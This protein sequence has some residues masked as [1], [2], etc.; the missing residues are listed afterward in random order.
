MNDRNIQQRD[1]EL[2]R[3]TE[4]IFRKNIYDSGEFPWSPYRCICPAKGHFAGIWNW[5]SAFHAI[6]MARIDTTLAK[7]SIL[8]FLQFQRQDGLLPDVIFE[9]GR[10]ENEYSKPPVFALATEVVYKA[11]GDKNFL[12]DVYPSL[13]KNVEFWD[14]LRCDR[15]LYHYDCDNKQSDRYLTCV[16]WESGWDN[17]VRW[18]D[19]ITELYAVDLNCF[20]VL[21][22]RSMN[23]ITETLDLTEEAD[24]WKERAETLETRINRTL[25]DSEKHYYADADRKTGVV[26]TVL[27]PASFMPLYIGIAS[28]EQAKYMCDIAKNNFVEKM[29]TVS[30]DN[31]AY[32]NDYWRG[33]TWLNVAYF[34]AKGLKRYG[35]SIADR[36]R[37]NILN[38]C[39]DEKDG[40]FE[41]YDS[42]TGKGQGSDRFSWSCVFIR[43]FILNW[44]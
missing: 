12:Q 21:F 28:E 7:E 27:T 39:F 10:I 35:F 25:W 37:E 31:P 23:F 29:P 22:F 44:D 30:F 36:I 9:D 1:A 17:A 15:G 6:G 41:N 43:E 13:K 2:L 38:M 11:D 40:I 33:P 19:G 5:D 34:A 24:C 4:E 18:D 26:G 42:K 8:G 20:M 3:R 32:S 14:K 16:K